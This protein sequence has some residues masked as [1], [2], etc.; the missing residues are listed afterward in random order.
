M[1]IFKDQ[2]KKASF[3]SSRME[4]TIIYP[5]SED[6]ENYKVKFL[7]YYTITTLYSLVDYGDFVGFSGRLAE[8]FIKHNEKLI[9]NLKNLGM[10][11]IENIWDTVNRFLSLHRLGYSQIEVNLASRKIIIYHYESP[12]VEYLYKISDLK[13]CNFLTVLY[14][15]ILSTLFEINIKLK[16]TECRNEKR[17][18]FCI[19]EM[20]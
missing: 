17:R 16:E 3:G 5:K 1:K 8:N 12:F 7:D 11:D 4:G 15:N 18:D 19:F 2:D 20:A 6:I 9:N 14:S 13:V 10:E